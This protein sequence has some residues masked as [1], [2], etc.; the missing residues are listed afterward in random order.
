MGLVRFAVE[1][2]DVGCEEATSA[3]MG[4]SEGTQQRLI[5]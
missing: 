3:R 4:R 5:G 2:C 1:Q